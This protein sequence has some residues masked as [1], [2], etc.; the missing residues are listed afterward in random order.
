LIAVRDHHDGRT[1]REAGDC[2]KDFVLRRHIDGAGRLVEG[3]QPRPPQNRAREAE[4]L[5]LAARNER[6]AFTEHR[7]E[8]RLHAGHEIGRAG[9]GKR[10]PQIGFGRL[11]ACP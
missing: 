5:L 11:R 9:D 10:L 2:F 7:V 6:A 3:E 1:R 8:P 4:P